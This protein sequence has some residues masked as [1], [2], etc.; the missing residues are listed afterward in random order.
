M[1]YKACNNPQLW[2]REMQAHQPEDSGNY[3]WERKETSLGEGSKQVS[4]PL[5]VRKMTQEG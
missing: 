3:H 1:S 5:Q 2:L 4:Q